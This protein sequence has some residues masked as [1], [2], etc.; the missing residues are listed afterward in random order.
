MC[1]LIV[2]AVVDNID[3]LSNITALPFELLTYQCITKVYIK[4]YT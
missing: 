4:I 3:V 2:Y 1:S